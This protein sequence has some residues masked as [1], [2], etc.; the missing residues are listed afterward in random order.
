MFSNTITHRWPETMRKN[1]ET[2]TDLHNRPHFQSTWSLWNNWPRTCFSSASS[3]S[4][5]LRRTASTLSQCLWIW[6]YV[7][8]K[9]LKERTWCFFTHNQYRSFSLT[10]IFSV[11]K[12]WNWPQIGR[13][14]HQTNGQS[15]GMTLEMGAKAPNCW[16]NI[17]ILHYKWV[18]NHNHNNREQFQRD[19]LPWS[20]SRWRSK[21]F[22]WKSA[23][24]R[25]FKSIVIIFKQNDWICTILPE[26][27]NCLYFDWSGYCTIQKRQTLIIDSY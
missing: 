23:D 11:C 20:S 3:T 10:S 15:H 18:M 17:T 5:K 8:W 22:E 6:R 12:S 26:R 9:Y 13:P 4:I 7:Y 24:D 27:I 25:R 19:C 2:T 14:K 1:T 21:R 16:V